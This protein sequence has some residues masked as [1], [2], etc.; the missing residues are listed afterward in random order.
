[1]L[2]AIAQHGT[3]TLNYR[4]RWDLNG[5]GEY[6]DPNE[7]FQQASST[8][9]DNFFAPLTLK[10]IFPNADGDQIYYLKIEQRR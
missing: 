9:Y 3:C 4:Y 8:N 1:M 10:I 5:D 2:Q 6:N 7:E